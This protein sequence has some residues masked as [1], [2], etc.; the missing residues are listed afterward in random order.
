MTA[1]G[2]FRPVRLDAPEGGSLARGGVQSTIGLLAQGLLR[3][4]AALLVGHI[5]GRGEF[6]VVA[7]AIA[8]ATI[9]SLLWPTTAGA[10]ASKFFAR[11]RG[12]GDLG[13]LSAI[14]AHLRTRTL[15]A[16]LVL[17]LAAIP[18]WVFYDG[19][20]WLGG[21]CVAALAI[22]YSGYIFT[23]GVQFG[24][25]QVRRATVWDLTSVAVGLLGITV[26]LLVGVR[27][28]ALVLALAAAY[29]LYAL[30]GWPYRVTGRPEREQ[31][32]E[33]DA[34]VL[35][36][37]AGALAST[38]FL[39]FS[40]I[41]AGLVG[42]VEQAGV[43]A[44]A[45]SLATPASMLAASL[46][47]VLLPSLAEAWGRGDKA[48]FHAQSDTATRA[49]ATVMVAIFGALLI[50]SRLVVDLVWGGKY[51]EARDLLP[52]LVLAV[53]ATNLAVGSVNSLTTRSRR[54]VRLTMIASVAGM[55][56]G[57]LVWLVAAPRWGNTGIAIGYLCGTT[58]VA[59]IPVVVAWRTGGHRWGA[60]FAKVGVAVAAMVGI[61]VLQRAADLPVVLDLAF[62]AVFL[63]CWLL[64]NRATVT[65]LL[66]GRGQTA[67]P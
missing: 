21:L 13:G 28:P 54:G 30:A 33:I 34:F 6:G 59:A 32:R 18:V 4:V 57:V 60:L 27:G 5:A 26:L 67:R 66:R 15:L 65:A 29:G 41:A 46:S 61:A 36:G 40:Q 49:L 42:G 53:L 63:V 45:L 24:A 35:F 47:L 51:P 17:G 16:S 62:A 37:A 48:A 31:R 23:R 20:S 38:G 58:V 25:G 1:G 56:V 64:A 11:A 50:G 10:A 43:Y 39:Q 19:G 44:S 2:V 8:A 9:L 3:F 52:I 14:A 22:A 12:A 7:S 55:A